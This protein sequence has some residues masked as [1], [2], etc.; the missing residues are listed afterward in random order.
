MDNQ[1]EIKSRQNENKRLKYEYERIYLENA[2]AATLRFFG[3][4]APPR[5]IMQI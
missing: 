4:T 1:K 2:N 5:G 3:P